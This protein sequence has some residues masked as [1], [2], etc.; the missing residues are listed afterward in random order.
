MNKTI[1]AILTCVPEKR[2]LL[3]DVGNLVVNEFGESVTLLK[4]TTTGFWFWKRISLELQVEDDAH[5]LYNES[6]EAVINAIFDRDGDIKV[7]L[8]ELS[9]VKPEEIEAEEEEPSE[10]GLFE[11]EAN[12]CEVSEPEKVQESKED[13]AE[14]QQEESPHEE[15]EVPAETEET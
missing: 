3:T 7:K 13:L 2:H 5:Y 15:E 8:Y 9:D 12:E 6:I 4:F 11:N 14:F 1:H 10:E